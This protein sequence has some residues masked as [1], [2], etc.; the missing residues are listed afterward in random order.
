MTGGGINMEKQIL[1]NLT[2]LH[3]SYFEDQQ[4]VKEYPIGI[5][6]PI[7]PTPPGNYRVIEKLEFSQL[8]DQDFR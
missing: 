2:T 6:K 8:G 7:T 1:V 3:C 4:L 5:G